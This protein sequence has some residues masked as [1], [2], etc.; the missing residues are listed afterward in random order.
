MKI[1]S[2]EFYSSRGY[3]KC[4]AAKV[5][6]TPGTGQIFINQKEINKYFTYPLDINDVLYPLLLV[7]L[8][9]NY[10]VFIKVKGGGRKGQV[11]AIRLAIARSLCLINS[12]NKGLLKQKGLLVRDS[13]VKERRKYGLKKARKAPQYSKR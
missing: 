8:I 4:A 13:R 9:D 7:N 10:N 12:N 1:N 6:L 5:F 11:E 3:R 2:E